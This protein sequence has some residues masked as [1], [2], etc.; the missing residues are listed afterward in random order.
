MAT[1]GIYTFKDDSSEHH[2]Y[3]HY[4]NYPN[5]AAEYFRDTLPLAWPL[6]RFEADEFA[7]AFVAAVK[8]GP[9]QVR[10]S[11]TRYDTI[12][13]EWGYTVY[14][15]GNTLM[16][17]VDETDYWDKIEEVLFFEGPMSEFLKQHGMSK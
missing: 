7:M 17:R 10:A 14:M 16:V 2:V 6:P 11:K 15:K 9:G 4:D 3:V 8:K 12:N 5:G 13:V 1:R